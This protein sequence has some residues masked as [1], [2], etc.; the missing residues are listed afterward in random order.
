MSVE[1]QLSILQRNLVESATLDQVLHGTDIQI[2]LFHQYLPN[3]KQSKVLVDLGGGNGR[4]AVELQRLGYEVQVRDIHSTAVELARK[5]GL[6]LS[7]VAD[8]TKFELGGFLDISSLLYLEFLSGVYAQGLFCNLVGSQEQVTDAFLAADMLLE[9]GGYFF[10]ADVAR[11]DCHHQAIKDKL[12]DQEFEKWQAKWLKRYL[13]N[14]QLGLAYGS[15]VVGNPK[16]KSNVW[17]EAELAQVYQGGDFERFAQHLDIDLFSQQ[18]KEQGFEIVEKIETVWRQ[19]TKPLAGFIF[20]CKKADQYKYHP[21]RRDVSD[22]LP[23][24]ADDDYW[25]IW[26]K[27][28][29]E[30]DP[31]IE[32]VYPFIKQISAREK[33]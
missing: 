4:K 25:S 15:F 31:R 17:N 20:V 24:R 11:A 19:D 26:A 8:A 1:N 29:L 6:F 3:G 23:P 16:T 28:L 21:R 33:N 12:G 14:Q 30:V 5:K 13:I 2:S 32:R 22:Q 27:L 10:I 7:S 18:L 9:P